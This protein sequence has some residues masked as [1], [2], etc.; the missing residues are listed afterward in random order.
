VIVVKP[1]GSHFLLLFTLVDILGKIITVILFV[2]GS[3]LESRPPY[4]I[5]DGVI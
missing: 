1:P 4:H 5:E 3:H 2:V